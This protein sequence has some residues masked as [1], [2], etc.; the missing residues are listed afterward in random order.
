M[1]KIDDA[2]RDALSSEDAEFLARFE[3]EPPVVVQAIGIFRGAY[4]PLNVLFLAAFLVVIAIGLFAVWK[5]ATLEDV[6][7]MLHW[8]AIAAFC[9]VVLALIR[10][11]FFME[12]QTNRL[13]REIKRLE[14]Q[15]ARLGARDAV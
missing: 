11:W 5:F 6:R 3:R 2:I 15:I 14:L 1:S 4:G 10:V 12:L 13:V 9:V 8:G 7:A